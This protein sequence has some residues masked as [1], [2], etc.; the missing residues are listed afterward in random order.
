MGQMRCFN[1]SSP[2]LRWDAL[3]KKSKIELELI[4]G[5]DQHLFIEKGLRDGKLIASP[6]FPWQKTFDNDLAAIQTHQSR[7]ELNKPVYVGM[8]I[9][10]QSKQFMYDFYQNKSKK[11]YGDNWDLLYADTESL[12][13]GVKVE[14]FYKETWNS[15]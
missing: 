10:D 5:Y 4:T 12:L 9:L 7:L 6:A 14:D 2:G 8:S 1:N 15:L 13:L 3:L 11:L